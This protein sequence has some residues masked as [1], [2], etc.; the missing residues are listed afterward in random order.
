MWPTQH[1]VTLAYRLLLQ[2]GLKM[3]DVHYATYPVDN[4][5]ELRKTLH[6]LLDG[7]QV[8]SSCSRR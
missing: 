1:F 5:S 3:Q 2:A 8:G 4:V 7:S 6:T